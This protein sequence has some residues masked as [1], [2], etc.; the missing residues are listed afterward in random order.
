MQKNN[1]MATMCKAIAIIIFC[2]AFIAGFGMGVDGNG[3]AVFGIWAGGFFAGLAFLAIGEIIKLLSTI[4]QKLMIVNEQLTFSNL[5]ADRNT[6][7]IVNA[8]GY[9]LKED[10]PDEDENGA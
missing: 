9:E 2:V 1:G 10:E 5:K 6:E 3:G 7:I 8:L 4:N